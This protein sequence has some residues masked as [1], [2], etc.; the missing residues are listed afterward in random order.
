M[1]VD[2]SLQEVHH[3]LAVG[4]FS[5]RLA[6]GDGTTDVAKKF[7]LSAGRISRKRREFMEGWQQFQGA[8]A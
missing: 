7:G 5:G 1:L 6:T 2:V 4:Q 3:V 8:V